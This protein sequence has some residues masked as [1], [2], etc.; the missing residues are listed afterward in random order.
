[1]SFLC[2]KEAHAIH[3]GDENDA[4]QCRKAQAIVLEDF[5]G[6]LP[7]FLSTV[8]LNAQLKFYPWITGLLTEF[9]RS[10]RQLVLSQIKV[11]SK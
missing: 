1:M 2:A 5:L 7:L 4:C 8:R 6:W 9:L 3:K 10:E 11:E